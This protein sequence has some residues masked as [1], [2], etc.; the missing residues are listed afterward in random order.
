MII[1]AYAIGAI[2]RSSLRGECCA[3]TKRRHCRRVSEGYL[4]ENAFVG[5][6]VELAPHLSRRSSAD[7]ETAP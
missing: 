1:A 4:G 5:S 6:P 2:R 7:E 3:R